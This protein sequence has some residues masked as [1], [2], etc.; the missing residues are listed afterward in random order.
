MTDTDD[1][2]TGNDQRLLT[3]DE[4]A[5]RWQVSR[6]KVVQLA[7]EGRIPVVRLGRFPRFRLEAI[8]AWEAS[9]EERPR[10]C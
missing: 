3:P 2:A 8:E 10:G 9:S 5:D 4:I 6:K 1:P 7:R